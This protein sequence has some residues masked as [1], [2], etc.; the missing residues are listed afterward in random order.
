MGIISIASMM[1]GIILVATFTGCTQE[2]SVNSS[3]SGPSIS[4]GATT[5]PSLDRATGISD[6]VTD[7]SSDRSPGSP[8]T[9]GPTPGSDS[10][11]NVPTITVTSTPSGATVR[12]NWVHS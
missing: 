4:S 10:P 9:D 5:D 11:E 1:V 8:S 3:N 6:A 12:L 2:G 7:F